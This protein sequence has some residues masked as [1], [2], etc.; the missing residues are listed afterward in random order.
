LGTEKKRGT[1]FRSSADE[2][3]EHLLG[4]TK[5]DKVKNQSIRRKTGAQSIVKEIKQYQ[6]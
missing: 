5:L 6:Q 2:I 1:T 4:V 3:F